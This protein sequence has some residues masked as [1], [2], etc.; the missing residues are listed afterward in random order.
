[1]LFE[2]WFAEVRQYLERFGSPS[3]LVDQ[4]N[5]PVNVAEHVERMQLA[6]EDVRN[7]GGGVEPH[8][9]VFTPPYEYSVEKPENGWVDILSR[10]GV[11]GPWARPLQLD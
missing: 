3:G 7:A 2:P 1:M 11:G 10:A 5:S 8:D 6:I 9:E 4:N